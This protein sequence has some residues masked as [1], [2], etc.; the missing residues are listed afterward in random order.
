[1]RVLIDGVETT[2]TFSR[3]SGSRGHEYLTPGNTASHAFDWHPR[4]GEKFLTNGHEYEILA[5]HEG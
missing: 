2:L 5:E 3:T 1:M 4:P